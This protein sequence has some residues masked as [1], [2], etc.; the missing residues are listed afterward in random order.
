MHEVGFVFLLVAG[1]WKK[2]RDAEG[3]NGVPGGLSVPSGTV[4][5]NP[6]LS[7]MAGMK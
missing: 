6:P 2:K 5:H 1:G 3:A 4:Q 7:C